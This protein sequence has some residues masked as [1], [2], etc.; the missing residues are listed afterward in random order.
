LPTAEACGA[1]IDFS[2]PLP[3]SSKNEMAVLPAPKEI[4]AS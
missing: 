1:L 4:T 3:E 2:S